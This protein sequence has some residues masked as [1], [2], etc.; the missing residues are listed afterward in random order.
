VPL[1]N[2][3][4]AF[5]GTHTPQSLASSQTIAANTEDLSASASSQLTN[6]TND[7]TSMQVLPYLENLSKDL[8]VVF[9]K[10]PTTIDEFKVAM[11]AVSIRQRTYATDDN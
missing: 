7:S 1:I 5:L 4:S 6:S 11:N 3:V 8:D 10:K 2:V 9:Q